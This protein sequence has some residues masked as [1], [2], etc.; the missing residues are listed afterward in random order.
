[1]NNRKIIRQRKKRLGIG[2]M[3]AAVLVLLI[4]I[5]PDHLDPK[6]IAS[7]NNI[8]DGVHRWVEDIQNKKSVLE[9]KTRSAQLRNVSADLATD[10]ATLRELCTLRAE[11]ETA[12]LD[13]L[14]DKEFGTQEEV[15]AQDEAADA[16]QRKL[17]EL[18]Q[19]AKRICGR[20]HQRA[21]DAEKLLA[22]TGDASLAQALAEYVATGNE[23]QEQRKET[24]SKIARKWLI[25]KGNPTPVGV[26]LK[27]SE[28]VIDSQLAW[29]KGLQ[30]SE[31]QFDAVAYGKE[32]K[33]QVASADRLLQA[34]PRGDS[35][36]PAHI[37]PA[38]APLRH[39]SFGMGDLSIGAEGDLARNLVLPLLQGW[40]KTSGYA[41]SLQWVDNGV[42]CKVTPAP[43][44][45]EKNIDIICMTHREA[46]DEVSQASRGAHMV[47]YADKMKIKGREEKI[48]ADATVF[49]PSAGTSGKMTLAEIDSTPKLRLSSEPQSGAAEQESADGIAAALFAEFDAVPETQ[50]KMAVLLSAPQRK[51]LIGAY[52]SMGA[53]AKAE[54]LLQIC[55]PGDRAY[56]PNA[57]NIATG[58]YWYTYDINCHSGTLAIGWQM[59]AFDNYLRGSA[60]EPIIRA[61]HFVPLNKEECPE[62]RLLTQQDIPVQAVLEVMKAAK[63]ENNMQYGDSSGVTSLRGCQLPYPIYFP[64]GESDGMEL[65]NRIDKAILDR[66]LHRHLDALHG[67]Y[68][69]LIVVITGHADIRGESE[70]NAKL[71]QKRA[72]N[73]LGK[74]LQ[75]IG[76]S[77]LA[78]GSGIQP[79][80]KKNKLWYKSAENILVISLGC[81]TSYN[82]CPPLLKDKNGVDVDEYYRK[83]RRAAIHVIVPNFA[84]DAVRQRTETVQ[85]QE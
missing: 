39:L 66:G 64:T 47:F 82:L 75:N 76:G 85:P 84:E 44:D 63:M 14:S 59:E 51:M 13:A 32:L 68:T 10:F 37:N 45:I 69:N 70:F 54:K 40:L 20:I 33:A 34:F 80:R 74:V 9:G 42:R 55:Y 46:L 36:R 19:E 50:E 21:A 29:L 57:I 72:D 61:Q 30:D 11:Q 2:A 62:I 35:Y 26:A 83:D 22:S 56:A 53:L 48:C 79:V 43:G 12:R 38:L 81:S 67:A 24:E 60:A 49:V 25:K 41:Y 4:C 7:V 8:A 15:S 65:D 27:T 3:V 1:M 28:E 31:T 16:I 6:L 52:H 23:L 5:W 71:S 18:H 17:E 77:L 58:Q 78:P 73:F